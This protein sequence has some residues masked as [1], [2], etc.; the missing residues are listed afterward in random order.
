MA[1]LHAARL[2]GS[3]LRCGTSWNI[4][5]DVTMQGLFDQTSAAVFRSRYFFNS[6]LRCR[7][8]TIIQKT[9]R[10]VRRSLS[11][12]CSSHR[13]AAAGH[14]G[15]TFCMISLCAWITGPVPLEFR[16]GQ[17]G[18]W[19]NIG[20]SLLTLKIYLPNA[21]W[22]EHLRGNHFQYILPVNAQL[23]LKCFA[24][25]KPF[26][27]L[28]NCCEKCGPMVCFLGFLLHLNVATTFSAR[29]L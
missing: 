5:F 14:E 22:G 1:W 23:K 3:G 18:A 21:G 11:K 2:P 24:S 7:T 12:I 27:Q 15:M 19:L 28:R 20:I 6:L 9:F 29:R 26:G 10:V 4:I 16:P 25:T 13:R 17:K 8:P